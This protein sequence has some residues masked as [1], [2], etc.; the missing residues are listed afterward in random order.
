[1]HPFDDPA[2]GG[3]AQHAQEARMT[4][5]VITSAPRHWPLAATRCIYHGK[6]MDYETAAFIMAMEARL[7][8][9]LTIVQGCYN[10]GGVK[11]SAGTHDGGG[12]FDLE[13][14]DWERKVRVARELG[15]FA[16]HRTPIPGVWEEHI[17]VG[18]RNHPTLSP[19]A[20]QQQEFFDQ[21]PRKNGLAGEAVDPDQYPTKYPAPTFRYPPKAPALPTFRTVDLNDDWANLATDVPGLV[22]DVRPLLMGVQEGWRVRYRSVVPRRWGV[23]QIRTNKATAGVAVLWDKRKLQPVGRR[24]SP[25]RMGRGLHVIGKGADTRE[26]PV[27]WVD[28]RFR[29]GVQRGHLPRV[30]RLASVHYPPQ[31]DRESWPAFDAHLET[32][33]KSSPLPVVL[34]M[35]SNQ[36][37]GP[38]GLLGGISGKYAWHAVT[39]SIDGTVTSLPVKAVKQLPKRTSDHHPVVV[40]LG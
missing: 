38:E 22:H 8:Y 31:R 32:W 9:E 3:A 37:G 16:W 28:L 15:A 19:A 34:F 2:A 5:P 1:M 29:D 14:W 35:D 26:R 20:R 24:R 7:G 36:H 13:P 40:T 17:H 18:I 6:L 4:T 25:L 12:V 10:P 21:K 11:A 39:D 33:V 30:F 23:Y 27:V